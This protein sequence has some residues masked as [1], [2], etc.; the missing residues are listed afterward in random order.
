MGDGI[1]KI[2][3][4]TPNSVNTTIV[5]CIESIFSVELDGEAI[6]EATVDGRITPLNTGF[7][8]VMICSFAGQQLGVF[9]QIGGWG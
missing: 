7:S 1:M 5:F 9:Y 8:V 2:V 6:A 3:F 4:I